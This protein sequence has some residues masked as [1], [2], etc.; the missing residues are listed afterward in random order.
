MQG[1][2]EHSR[3]LPASPCHLELCEEDLLVCAK[4]LDTALTMT[5][6]LRT[7][8]LGP[9][10]WLSKHFGV[11]PHVCLNAFVMY[12]CQRLTFRMAH[13]TVYHLCKQLLQFCRLLV[14]VR[15]FRKPTPV[16]IRRCQ[17]DSG[18]TSEQAYHRVSTALQNFLPHSDVKF[19]KIHKVCACTLAV[20]KATLYETC[21]STVH[22]LQYLGRSKLI[23]RHN[24]DR[25]IG[26]RY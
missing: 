3:C 1:P 22:F 16:V 5:C 21:T 25:S 15:A 10:N 14:V 12:I 23:A 18:C 4:L 11:E 2:L 9:L 26:R 17:G 20:Q 13:V 19:G 24:R 6:Q 8:R 7:H